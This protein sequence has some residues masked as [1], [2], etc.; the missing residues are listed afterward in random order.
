MRNFR[1]GRNAFLIKRTLMYKRA[2]RGFWQWG[3]LH[4]SIYMS[5][6]NPSGRLVNRK[7]DNIH[8]K[9]EY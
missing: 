2:P 7:V 4:N 9:R 5:R 8:G 6:E 3:F 1:S